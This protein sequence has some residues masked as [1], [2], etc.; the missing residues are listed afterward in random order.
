MAR[1]RTWDSEAYTPYYEDDDPSLYRPSVWR[2]L[3]IIAIVLVPI[4]AGAL[5]IYSCFR[6]YICPPTASVAPTS[7]AMREPNMVVPMTTRPLADG[8]LPRRVDLQPAS[9]RTSGPV[10]AVARA[11]PEPPPESQGGS[12]D[13]SLLPWPGVARST[14]ATPPNPDVTGSFAALDAVPLPRRRPRPTAAADA[15]RPPAARTSIFPVDGTLPPPPPPEPVSS[16][17]YGTPN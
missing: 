5:L 2:R 14:A 17:T 3:L 12:S 10:L 7:L 9:S 15:T 4:V 6:V 8:T 13:P 1:H 16:T 11:T